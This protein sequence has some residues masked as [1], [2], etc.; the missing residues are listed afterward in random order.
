MT[1]DM[2]D[3]NMNGVAQPYTHRQW[4]H[5]ALAVEHGDP[6]YY[7]DAEIDL[8]T[9]EGLNWLVEKCKDCGEGSSAEWN[10]TH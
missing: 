8:M 6:N 5:D 7:T 2:L 10:G 4:I 9:D 1:R 3:C